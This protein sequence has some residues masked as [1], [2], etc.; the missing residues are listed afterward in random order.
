[1]ISIKK[2][3]K[4]PLDIP[5]FTCDLNVVGS[6]LNNHDLTK[7]LNCY[8]FLCVVGRPGSGKTSLA[9]AMITQ[10]KPRFYKKTHHH[11]IL[12]MPENSIN[13]L[14]KNPFE[15]LDPSNIFHELNNSTISE[16]YD[17]IDAWSKEGDKTILFID[18]MTS[19]LKKSKFI[20]DTMKKLI[21]NRR[22][23]K[24][25]IIITAQ[26][27]P[28][29]PL[30]VRKTITSLILFKPPKMEFERVFDELIESKKE[31]FE[32]IMKIVYDQPHNF[33]FVN[34]PSQTMFKNWDEIIINDSDSDSDSN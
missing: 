18:D 21:Y 23:L 10:K 3:K 7:Y 15:K 5:N 27:Y 31:I 12:F 11:I 29:I 4:L 24:L 6:H 2:N 17:K 9:I 25:N 33:L 34:V 19:D 32:D 26:V 13:S 22:H 20:V 1:M 14:K 16:A 28:N 30:D 8:G